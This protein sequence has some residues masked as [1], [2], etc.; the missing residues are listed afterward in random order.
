MHTKVMNVKEFVCVIRACVCVPGA[1]R[2]GGEK[3][4]FSF[5]YSGAFV[6]DRN[7][8]KKIDRGVHLVEW[9]VAET[10]KFVKK[11]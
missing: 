1:K 10:N 7:K 2:D 3:I 11:K 8:K 9:Q 4:S 5:F 6:C